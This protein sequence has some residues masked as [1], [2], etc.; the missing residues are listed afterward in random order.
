MS[1]DTNNRHEQSEQG[2]LDNEME[3]RVNGGDR[4]PQTLSIVSWLQKTKLDTVI[5]EGPSAFPSFCRFP[6]LSAILLPPIVRV[7]LNE[8]INQRSWFVYQ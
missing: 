1:Q 6:C 2:Y 7:C 4:N 3:T 8:R 5:N